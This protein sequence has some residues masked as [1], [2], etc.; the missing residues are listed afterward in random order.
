MSL[1]PVV[2]RDDRKDVIEVASDNENVMNSDLDINVRPQTVGD[3]KAL[4]PN[5]DSKQTG[6]VFSYK[7][8]N[9]YNKFVDQKNA[10]SPKEQ[11]TFKWTS[12]KDD[13]LLTSKRSNDTTARRF[14]PEQPISQV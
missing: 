9:N 3:K 4:K 6:N 2:S 11:N 12:D 10:V 13:I 5:N 8:Y 14:S 7:I 1:S